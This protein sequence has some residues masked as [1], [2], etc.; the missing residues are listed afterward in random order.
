MGESRPE[1]ELGVLLTILIAVASAFVAAEEGPAPLRPVEQPE[2]SCSHAKSAFAR[3]AEEAGAKRYLLSAKDS[4]A[5]TT[6]VLHY[7][8][9]LDV[10][11]LTRHLNG[12]NVMTV[13]SLV[14][15]NSTF[16]FWLH[17][18]FTITSLRVGGFVAQWKRLGPEVIEVTLDRSY[19]RGEQYEVRVG[20]DGFPPDLGLGS[21]VFDVQGG[22]P[23]V[24]TLSEP[25]FS[26]TW[27]PVKEDSRDKATGE[28]LITVPSEMT[29]VS[30]GVLV[31]ID[32]VGGGR[33]RHHWATTYPMSPY[34]FAFSATE[35]NTFS[36]TFT[37]DEGSMPVEFFI[38]PAFDTSRNRAGW[39][40][41]VAML[42]TFSSLYGLYPFIDEKY[43]I[44][45]FPFTGGM[46]H[47]TATGQGRFTESLTAHEL[48][49]QWWGDMVTC[50]TWHDIWLNEGF[51][52]YSEALWF[53]HHTG[54]PDSAALRIAMATRRPSQLDGTVYVHDTSSVSRIFSGNYTYRKAAWVL[55]M[56]RHVVE[57]QVFFEILDLYRDRFEYATATTEDFQTVAEEAWGGDLGWFFSEWVY[58]GG[59]PAYRFGWQE[60]EIGDQRYLELALEQTQDS[61][62]F[63]MP[64]DV[65]TVEL[66]EDRSYT[67]WS[68]ARSQHFLIPVSAPV[69]HLE[70]DPDAW[71]LTSSVTAGPFVEGPPKVVEVVPAP[72]S[73]FRPR[74]PESIAVT[75]HEDV[76]AA[77]SDFSLRNG[78][79]QEIGLAVS[80]DPATFTATIVPQK[81]LPH[82]Q[83][84]L[85]V[86]DEIVD[87]AGGL[88]LDGEL[89][90][91]AGARAFPSGDGVPGGDSV[92]SFKVRGFPREA[93]R[94][95]R[96]RW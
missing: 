44:Y 13:S 21:I 27:W 60:H 57:D 76:V 70:V 33:R 52:T 86:S 84:E 63:I 37:H 4:E 83:Y 79:G 39:M 3:A 20:Y 5:Q 81:P 45:Q 1:A 73:R 67:V 80:Y 9:E 23:V 72:G 35:Y 14:D 29:V 48:A 43:A 7:R 78:R 6:D 17:S 68:D 19:D 30:N 11:P 22:S 85:S 15:D 56:L 38:Y 47:Q 89:A 61:A 34:L 82:G 28:L 42:D 49:H 58:G 96:P 94:R 40:G 87:A 65:A 32:A 69:D 8:L 92:I 66:D 88:A 71:I 16:S 50:A 55:H 53:E 51:A 31:G 90:A 54:T 41:S 18:D 59:A 26:Y 77:A 62:E 64:V 10:D 36:S 95:S 91:S 46:E 74:G 2:P 25:W 75:F 93:P 12:T 24:S